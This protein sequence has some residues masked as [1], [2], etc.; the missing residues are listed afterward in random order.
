MLSINN[1]NLQHGSKH[2]FRD[3]SV[4]V[5]PE[6]RIGLVGVNGTGK[7]TLLKIMSGL[8]ETDPGTV[9]RAS[10]FTVAYLPQEI[11]FS[12]SGHT[13]YEEA[14]SAFAEVLTQQR[15]LA[16]ISEQ[17]AVMAATDPRLDSLLRR[18]GELQHCLEGR[19]IFTI[20]PQIERI[21]FGLGFFPGGPEKGGAAFLRRLDHAAAPG[22]AAP[23]E[24]LPAP[25]GRAHQPPGPGL[26]DLAGGISPAVPGGDHRHLP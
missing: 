4:Q 23:A 5:Y 18:Q 20:R 8:Q 21:L 19:D 14:E 15:E 24:T 11:A 3:V 16:E 26:P 22:Q 6:D 12:G 1:L 13:L 17:L 10:W 25:P 7:S 9:N 2:L